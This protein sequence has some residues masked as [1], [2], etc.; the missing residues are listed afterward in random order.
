M[1]R[2]NSAHYLIVVASLLLGACSASKPIIPEPLVKPRAEA[3]P[4]ELAHA[5]RLPGEMPNAVGARDNDLKWETGIQG[6]PKPPPPGLLSTVKPA[7]P[8]AAVK[9]EANI[10]VAFDQMPLPNFVQA[11]YGVILKKNYS[12]DPQVASRQD[13]VT[14]RAAQAQTPSQIEIASRLLLKTYG[15]AVTDL[16][17]GNYRIALD[18]TRTGYAP[19]ILRGR[20]LPTVP[21]PL[22]PIYQLVELQAVRSSEVSGWLTKV[23]GDKVS[24]IDVAANNTLILSGQADNV[25]AVLEAIHVLD[26][27]LMKGRQSQR[28]NPVFWSAEELGKKLGEL[29][30]AEGYSVTTA[31]GQA[32]SFPINLIPI[33]GINALI[34]FAADP[35]VM[36]HIVEWAKELDKPNTSS[37]AGAGYF[38]YKVRYTNAENLARTMQAVLG[39][40]QAAT[41]PPTYPAGAVV[42]GTPAAPVKPGRVIVNSATNTLIFQGGKE[43]HTQLL[44]LLQELDKPA[45]SALIEVTVAEVTL[46]NTTQ[47]GVEWAFNASG[48]S[49]STY[50]GGT[51]G[52]VPLG[53]TLSTAGIGIGTG[54]LTIARLNSVGDLRLLLNML[55]TSSQA[56]V[57]S[58]PRILARN[59]ETAS[60]QVGSEIP[61]IDQQQTNAATGG[62]GVLQSV[63]YRKTGVILSV[64]PIIYAGDR[65]DLE[66]TQEVSDSTRV[67]VA[68]SPIIDTRKVQTQLSLKNG[69]PVLLGGL[70]SQNNSRAESGVPLLKD[71]PILGQLFRTNTDNNRKTEMLVLITPY[72][73]ADDHDAQEITDAF[74]NQLGE[75]AKPKTPSVLPTPESTAGSRQAVTKIPPAREKNGLPVQ[76]APV[77]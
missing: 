69:T 75:W 74:R 10:T 25:T 62:V 65:I 70:I 34:V 33:Q 17:A 6:T 63:Q 64:K 35:A 59:G 28:I 20:A 7:A 9:E 45:K 26:Q 14:F 4:A 47:L 1:T 67:G 13:L 21:L 30:T 5:E 11:I 37:G 18:N 76:S 52:G 15:V 43:N 58:S 50:T 72:I 66:V 19:E 12:M 51:L 23:F 73:V 3:L 54:G 40:A 38:T 22:R 24:I 53:A 46:D 68:G 42:V 2:K 27:P 29:L 31:A 44:N 61:T 32:G 39:E 41:P 71:I 57:L 36:Q 55:A 77:P 48:A 56:N 16:G 49:G 60:I 8:V